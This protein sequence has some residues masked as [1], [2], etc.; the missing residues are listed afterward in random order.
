[1]LSVPAR[2]LVCRQTRS[3]YPNAFCRCCLTDRRSNDHGLRGGS[4]DD[5]Q[6]RLMIIFRSARR[7]PAGRTC[8]GTELKGEPY[9]VARAGRVSW[10][11]AYAELLDIGSPGPLTVGLA[12]FCAWVAR[13]SVRRRSL[14]PKIMK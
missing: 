10:M 3:G 12:C 6:T 5:K 14:R 7:Y 13:S 1:V 9:R 2:I 11:G 8:A 4:N